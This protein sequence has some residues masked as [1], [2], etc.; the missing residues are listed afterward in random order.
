M[1]IKCLVNTDRKIDAGVGEDLKIKRI[2]CYFI[3]IK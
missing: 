1:N 3:G 2:A